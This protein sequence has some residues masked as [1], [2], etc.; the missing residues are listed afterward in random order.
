MNSILCFTDEFCPHKG[1]IVGFDDPP[2]RVKAKPYFSCRAKSLEAMQACILKED[3][4]LKKYGLKLLVKAEDNVKAWD[5]SKVLLQR[6]DRG[7]QL[8]GSEP[9]RI[10]V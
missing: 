4:D 1:E 5:P 8:D 3:G 9:D 6:L 7:E 10:E 2:T